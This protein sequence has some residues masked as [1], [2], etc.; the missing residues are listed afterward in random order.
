[1][2]LAWRPGLRATHGRRLE[3]AARLPESTPGTTGRQSGLLLGP[4]AARAEAVQ[5][6]HGREREP[7][8]CCRRWDATR[9]PCQLCRKTLAITFVELE[10]KRSPRWE[11]HERWAQRCGKF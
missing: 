2:Q 10:Q 7:G 6:A 5:V 8:A 4:A 1:M 9:F 3:G 11:T